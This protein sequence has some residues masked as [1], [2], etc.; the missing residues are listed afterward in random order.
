MKNIEIVEESQG[1]QCDN[2][3]CDWTDA[4]IGMKTMK[5]WINRPCPKCGENVLT[6]HDYNLAKSLDDIIA[7]VNTLSDEQLSKISQIVDFNT[8][9]TDP[10]A[11]EILKNAKEGDMINATVS[12]HKEVKI[13]IK[14][15]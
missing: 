15:E 9:F 4:T 7:F 11:L 12:M 1:L 5:D 2:P 14:K 13:D 8:L 3:K 6:E 10:N